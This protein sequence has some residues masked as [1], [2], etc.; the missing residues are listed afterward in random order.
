M[1]NN[2]RISRRT[3]LKGMGT[4]M[5]LPLL[6]AMIPEAAAAAD[7]SP[8]RMAFCFVPNGV[9]YGQWKLKDGEGA[10]KNFSYTLSPLKNL[11]DHVIVFQGLTHDKAR[12]NGDGSGD[13][14][15]SNTAFLTASQ[16]RKHKSDIKAGTSVDQVAAQKIGDKTVLPSLELGIERG[17]M[18]GSCDSGYSCAYSSNI[19]WRSATTPNP[20]ECNP[21]AVFKR[22]FGDPGQL[23]KDRERAKKIAYDKSVL[24][25]VQEDA[26]RLSKNLGGSDKRKVDEYL[27]S[28]RQV[29]KQIQA[30]SSNKKRPEP[31][32]T[33]KVPTGVPKENRDHL[34]VMANLMVLAFQ[35]DMTRIATF[36]FANDSSN[37]T[38]P[39]IGVREGHHSLSHHKRNKEKLEQIKKIDRYYVE[40]FAYLLERMRAVKEGDGCL[41]DHA[42]VV[43]GCAISDGNRHNHEDL[44]ILWGGGANGTVKTGRH[45][46]Y[47]RNTPM[48]N[49][50]LSMLDRMGVKEARFGDSTGRLQKLS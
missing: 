28:V 3:V 18:S 19:S 44:P 50:F 12:P 46:V 22:L 31:P 20:K 7:S 21:A 9:N 34:R 14:A 35:T 45:L 16:P 4:A 49:L 10:L 26:K 38:F 40:Q 24:D 33:F 37:R 39:W 23:A 8:L 30:A 2:G 42:M 47:R 36:S 13:H 29:E 5:A 48:A 25:L 1:L 27:E 43:Y 41:L 17:R 15:R 11:R 32:K 6:D